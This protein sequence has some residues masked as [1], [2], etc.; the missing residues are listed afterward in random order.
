MKTSTLK[1]ALSV[2]DAQF[3]H[4]QNRTGVAYRANKSDDAQ[5][6]YYA[7]MCDML[8]LLISEG[9]TNSTRGVERNYGRHFIKRGNG[10]EVSA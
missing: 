1:Y 8:N 10:Q 9:Y 4:A 6:A 3:A 5:Q 2:L 7:G